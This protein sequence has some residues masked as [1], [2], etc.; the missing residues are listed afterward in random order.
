MN[1]VVN[2]RSG[3]RSHV[4]GN[5]ALW[6]VEMHSVLVVNVSDWAGYIKPPRSLVGNTA[7]ECP[8]EY[9]SEQ[10]IVPESKFICSTLVLW[11][12][13]Q[14][15]DVCAQSFIFMWYIS[16]IVCS[17]VFYLVVLLR[18]WCQLC[19]YFGKHGMTEISLVNIKCPIIR[20]HVINSMLYIIPQLVRLCASIL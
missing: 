4:M 15:H 14:C 6:L 9:T 5:P 20:T 17:W 16:A 10:T 11:V 13:R 19:K 12:I 1:F 7:F 18:A 3:S 8:F 2:H